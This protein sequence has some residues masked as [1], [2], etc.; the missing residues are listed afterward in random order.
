MVLCVDYLFVGLCLVEGDVL[1][2][3]K[4]VLPT[5]GRKG[6]TKTN[7]H[8]EYN[9]ISVRPTMPVF[10]SPFEAHLFFS[11]CFLFF[12][13]YVVLMRQITIPPTHSLTTTTVRRH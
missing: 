4:K 1:Q 13:F 10:H 8:K 3:E 9:H 5:Q 2:H 7:R 6:K 11:C 12:L